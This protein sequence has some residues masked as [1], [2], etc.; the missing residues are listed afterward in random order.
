M[1][2][3]S[4]L[5]GRCGCRASGFIFPCH[6]RRGGAAKGGRQRDLPAGCADALVDICDRRLAANKR[7]QAAHGRRAGSDRGG[8]L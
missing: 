4:L 2:E 3:R 6:V 5:H 8:D 7:A 1:I